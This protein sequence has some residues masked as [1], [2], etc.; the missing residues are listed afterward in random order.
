MNKIT[1]IATALLLLT[2]LEVALPAFSTPAQAAQ[3]AT[4]SLSASSVETRAS[5]S[6]CKT[7]RRRRRATYVNY[8]GRR[9]RARYVGSRIR[10]ING[11]LYRVRYY[12]RY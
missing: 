11:R 7:K 2:G 9:V 3:P 4:A 12:R 10:R 8:R 6:V 5:T 1:K